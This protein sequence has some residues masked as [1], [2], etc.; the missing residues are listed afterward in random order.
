[1]HQP[2]YFDPIANSYV[3][4]WTY[5]HAIKDYADMAA[6]LEAHPGVRAVVN[7]SPTLLEQID[8]YDRQLTRWRARG[9]PITDPLLAALAE[10]KSVRD[11]EQRRRLIELCT[12]AHPNRVIARFPPYLRL[13][14]LAQTCTQDPRTLAYLSDTFFDDLLI[15]F[16]LAMLGETVRRNDSRVLALMA[17]EAD[18]SPVQRAQLLDV[19]HQQI[20]G[21]IA[22]YRALADCGAIELAM[23]P[24]A[25]PIL[26]LLLDLRSAREAL[27]EL[28]LPVAATYPGG[29]QRARWQIEQGISVFERYFHRRP[30]GCWPAEGAISTAAVQLLGEYDFKWIA[31]GRGVLSHS[32][33]E[34][35]DPHRPYRLNGGPTIVFRDDALSDRI[36]FEYASWH[37]DDAAADLVQ[38]L[39][40]IHAAA[41][42]PSQRMV[43]IIMDGENAWEYYYE[44]AFHFF[45]ALYRSLAN[46]PRLELTTFSDLLPRL[47]PC[48]LDRLVAG[49]WIYGTLSTWIGDPQ[50]NAAWDLLVAA[51]L[52]F[53]AI[54]AS[55]KL[56]PD[57]LAQ[58][59]QALGRCEASDWWWWF[60][61]ETDPRIAQEFDALF[62]AHL[63]ALYHALD[64]PVPD[65]V[66]VSLVT[67]GA[68]TGTV[69]AMRRGTAP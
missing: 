63:R 60:G 4:P 10:P 22:R 16:H 49:S 33:P 11:P 51:K 59:E 26:P 24:Y 58:A 3:L 46:D 55:G 69:G 30:A 41:P 19:I 62:R 23:N 36:G 68:G 53:D 27:P 1:M 5:L 43:A 8:D 9:A 42:E 28:E 6:H 17:H 25:H 66:N 50:K 35:A 31:S 7:F 32:L 29:E 38:H 47:P 67:P 45:G 56:A 37:G 54:I 15:W 52:D 48:P 12:R 20:G 21:I 2:S 64:T 34:A 57:R 18:Y 13:Y 61:R 39:V 65:A 44:N 14:T 40:N